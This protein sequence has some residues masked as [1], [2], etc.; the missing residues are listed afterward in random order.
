[1]NT[2]Y[3]LQHIFREVF[4]DA[5]LQLSP[6]LAMANCPDWDSV[7]TVQLVLAT[8]AEFGLRFTT[9]EVAQVRSVADLLALIGDPVEAL[10]SAA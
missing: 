9:D 7:A 5:T 6:E 1:M 3:R 2:F 8:E 10:R 4:D